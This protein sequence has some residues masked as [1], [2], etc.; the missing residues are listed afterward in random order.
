MICGIGIDLIEVSRIRDAIAKYGDRFAKRIYTSVEIEYCSSKKNAA[1]HYA[2]RFAAKEAAFKAMERGW[3]GDISWKE[4][5]VYN[6]PSGAPRIVFYGK[7][8]EL[9]KE[10]KVVRAF[11][12]ISHI[13][14]HATAVVVLESE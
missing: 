14:E 3:M 10:K 5:E 9:I 6:E 11:V 13:E 1:L 4:I 7:A 8:L 12:T 2:G